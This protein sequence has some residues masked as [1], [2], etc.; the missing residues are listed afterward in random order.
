[1]APAFP[2]ATLTLA[3]V[4]APAVP[5]LIAAKTSLAGIFRTPSV[6]A[7]VLLAKYATVKTLPPPVARF[8]LVTT[9]IGAEA[10]ACLESV[11]VKTMVPG[12]AVTVIELLTAKVMDTAAA[13]LVVWAF[14]RGAD[15]RISAS[16]A[17]TKVS[18]LKAFKLYA[19]FSILLDLGDPKQPP[20]F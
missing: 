15:K 9:A 7:A 19:P 14:D 11:A 16:A 18:I 2:A 10:V 3:S 17:M 13:L 20:V 5:P 6:K 1:M 12:V 4:Q 8:Q